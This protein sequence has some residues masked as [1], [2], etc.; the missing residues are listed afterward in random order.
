MSHRRGLARAVFALSLFAMLV[1]AAGALA[2]PVVGPE[3]SAFYTPP[4]P[5]PAGSAGQLVWYRP[6]TMNL[7]VPLPGNKVWTVLYQST[8]QKGSPDFVTGTVIVPTTRW[9]GKGAR[10][11]VTVGEG[12][13]G[14]APQC[15][16]SKQLTTGSEFDGAAIIDSLKAGYAVDVTDYQGYTNGAIP[17][18]TA[19]KAE[20]QAVLDVVRAGRQVPGSGLTESDP[21]Y[22]WGYSQGGQAVGWAGEVQSS[23]ASNVKLSGIVA[24]GV[25]ANLREFGAFAGPSATS[26]LEILSAIGL[27]AAYPEIKLGTLTPAGEKAVSEALSECVTQ[28]LTTLK[29]AN[30]QEF[31]T[32]HKTADTNSKPQNR[33]SGKRSKNRISISRPCLRR[34]TTS[35][36]WKTRRCR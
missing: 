36:A 33:H 18:Y 31:T 14:L 7:K 22:A 17:S 1:M 34:S 10:P 15:A 3:G 16:P 26:G 13:Q 8:D 35:T 6:A 5:T 25:P 20:G 4:S 11:V 12:T 32:E 19:G 24:G 23:Y 28:L 29:G 30:F 21:T 9:G 2:A 27:Q